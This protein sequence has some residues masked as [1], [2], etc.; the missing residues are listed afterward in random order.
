MSMASKLR[1]VRLTALCLAAAALLTACGSAADTG[2]TETE[3]DET[4]DWTESGEVVAD[5]YVADSVFSLCWDPDGS[6]NPV[7]ATSSTNML[8]WSLMYDSVFTVDENFA[9]SS[10]IVT[11]IE[12]SDYIWWMFTVDTSI[13][14]NDGS[15]LT[16]QDV[17]YS[18]QRAMQSSY[19]KNR[20]SVIYGISAMSTDTFAITTA[21]ADSQLTSVLNIPIIK[22]G[23]YNDAVPAGTGPYMLNED[24]DALVLFESNRHADEMPLNKIYL[25]SFDNT[26]DK[27][28]AFEDSV[29]DIVTNDPTGIYNLGY[30]SA[31]EV[32]YYTTTNMHYLGFNMQSLFF[33]SYARRYAMLFAVD[34]KTFAEEEM[35]GC[36]V[37]SAL[38]LLPTSELYDSEYA[39]KFSYDP[40]KMLELMTAAGVG[41]LDSD[42]EFEYDY[43]GIVVELNLKFIVNNDSAVKVREAR[44]I[45][46]ELN[47][48]GITTTLYELG[49]DDYVNCLLEG[50]YDFYYGEI[51]LTPD[52]SL[53]SLL[54]SEQDVSYSH[55]V[56]SQYA[57]LIKAY[58]GADDASRYEL[59]QEALRYVMENG[60]IVPICFE[61]RQILTHRGVVSGINATQYD[62]FNRFQDW[63]ITFD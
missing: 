1:R 36:A 41:D 17:A 58:L 63:T 18:I 25:R 46:E 47:A 5:A 27:I 39:A 3:R 11:N 38:P 19:Y 51:R 24:G 54:D 43:A 48:A 55:V 56:D 30:G 20:L 26:S 29:I 60:A 44:K 35:S 9:V 40:D 2:E 50:D 10:E 37:A 21:Y 33:S 59:Y 22:Y 12:T 57:E 16:A 49:Y 15:T 23:S 7:A 4:A 28:S 34:R 6:M 52:W 31:N 62:L 53:M 61:R 45:A 8:F 42:G 32:R 14:F 13:E